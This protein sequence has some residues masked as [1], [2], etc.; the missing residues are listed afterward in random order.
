[1]DGPAAKGLSPQPRNFHDDAWQASVTTEH[2]TKIIRLGGQSVGKSPTMPANPDLVDKGAVV[3][4]LTGKI[5][6]FGGR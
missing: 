5:R 3:A 4:A 1:G 2:I 6:G